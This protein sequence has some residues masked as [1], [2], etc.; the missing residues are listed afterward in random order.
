MNMRTLLIIGAGGHGRV[1]AETAQ[2]CGYEV[3]F[4][5]D[6]AGDGVVGSISDLEEFV[7]KYDGFFV[8]IG[9]NKMRHDLYDRL[10][11][12]GVEIVTLVHPT[13]YVSPTAKISEGVIV[14]P[15]SIVNTN[16]VIGI[17]A[18]VGVGAV[19][20]HDVNVG[21]YAHINAGAICKGGAIIKDCTKLEAGEVVHGFN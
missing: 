18:I 14:E 20:D 11:I 7:D 4:L 12:L 16:S 17:G 5:D 19:V 1:V 10:Q 9:N 8:G 13:S 6:K 21:A 3:S 15:M 2:A